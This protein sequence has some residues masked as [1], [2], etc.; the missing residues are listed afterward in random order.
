MSATAARCPHC[1]AM[2]ARS[3]I[4]AAPVPRAAAPVEARRPL[5]EVSPDEVRAILA[6]AS[7]KDGRL[8]DAEGDEPT[9]LEWLFVPHPRSRGAWRVLEWALTALTLP[10]TLI[11][12]LFLPFLW[13]GMRVARRRAGS[14]GV[15][16]W[17]ASIG[18]SLI[19]TVAFTGETSAPW[20]AL[21]AVPA[22][23]VILRELVRLRVRRRASGL[24]A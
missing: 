17:L 11:G 16:R 10:A 18:L 22:S 24:D 23:A 21:F 13:R 20:I 9:L 7:A 3:P 5:G 12:G 4:R 6:V 15:G 1:A 14:A 19:A 8:D 2:Q